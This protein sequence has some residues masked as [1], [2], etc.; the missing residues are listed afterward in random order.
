MASV[1]DRIRAWKLK[2]A[3]GTD[4]LALPNAFKAF[5]TLFKTHNLSAKIKDVLNSPYSIK[6]V[7]I[8]FLKKVAEL[9]QQE[10]S[11]ATDVFTH[12]NL[13]TSPKEMLMM[14]NSLA[15]ILLTNT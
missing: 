4:S 2:S 9:F 14:P 3:S 8:S 13:H 11:N 5:F 10:S 6:K 15:F 12:C 1:E 7:E